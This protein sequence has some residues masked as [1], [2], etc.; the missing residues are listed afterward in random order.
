MADIN[1]DRAKRQIIL[2]RATFEYDDEG[3]DKLKFIESVGTWDEVTDAEFNILQAYQYTYGYKIIE[4]NPAK[5]WMNAAA[6]PLR[7]PRDYLELAAA[8]ERKKEE[9]R[10]KYEKEGKAKALERKRKQL[11]RLKKELEGK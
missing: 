6:D 9:R 1:I 8:E 7:T 11:E 3:P 5:T 2:I 10:K 4:R